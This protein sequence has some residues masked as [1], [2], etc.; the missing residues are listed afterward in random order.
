MEKRKQLLALGLTL[1][2]AAQPLLPALA[3]QQAAEPEPLVTELDT[4]VPV[5]SS[6]STAPAAPAEDAADEDAPR[7]PA[8][9]LSFDNLEGRIRSGSLGVQALESSIQRLKAM[10]YKKLQS[11]RQSDLN[12]LEFQLSQAEGLKSL[13]LTRAAA[14]TQAA[15][16]GG[17][18]AA[19]VPGEIG[20]NTSQVLG[21]LTRQQTATEIGLNA[22]G[23][24]VYVMM[25]A[26]MQGAIDSLEDLISDL[27]NGRT[28]KD[29]EAGRTWTPPSVRCRICRTSLSWAGSRFT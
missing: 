15:T 2:L 26:N 23:S 25:E 17:L 16:N 21:N 14:T 18:I 24:A 13:G 6:G 27:K 4:L 22:L 1:A 28:Q 11:E 29:G 9:T 12:D 19:A 3:A 7:D 8:R 10:D 5:G 20:A